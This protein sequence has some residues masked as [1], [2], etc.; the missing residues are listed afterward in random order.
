MTLQPIGQISKASAE[1]RLKE[2]GSELPAPPE[3]FGAYVEAV[4]TGGL[5]LLSGVLPREGHPA[6]FI[7]RV[8]AELDGMRLALPC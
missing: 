2:L 3:P 8:G 7:G 5:L 1:H 4:Q 6:K